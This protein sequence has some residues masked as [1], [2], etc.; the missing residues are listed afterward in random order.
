M[1]NIDMAELY[2]CK[3]NIFIKDILLIALNRYGVIAD[4][5]DKRIRFKIKLDNTE[6]VF[7]M[8]VCV[9]TYPSPFLLKEGG[10]IFLNNQH[11]GILIEIEHD[12]CD[13]TYF[14]RNKTELTL[15]SNMRSQC[16][17]CKFCGSYQLDPED[18]HDLNT[19]DKLL[20]YL[21]ALLKVNG[22]NSFE[23]LDRITIC[24]GCFE[25]EEN[26][27]KHLIMVKNVFKKYGFNKRIR[28]IGSQLRSE[29]AFDI[30]RDE[31]GL[32]SLTLTLECFSR[33]NELMRLEKASLNF[34]E[35]KSVLERALYHNFSVN[36]LYILGLDKL[37]IMVK[38]MEELKP[39]INRFPGIQ[40]F[41]NFTSEQENYR[42]TEAKE[43]PYYLEARK[44]VEKI[45]E[46]EQY[47]PRSWE[48][49]RGLFYFTYN[50][51]D[52]KGI[53]I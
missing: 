26:L 49:Y 41:Q 39:Y 52:F 50:G 38:G 16:K 42:L 51:E 18:V 40:I 53:K 14:R 15:N 34:A 29:K 37:E 31:I 21:E 9:N 22:M 6:T 43:I 19:E 25:N 24:T 27:V 30:L 36:Y 48:N 32:F 33:R 12:T 4:I 7:Y 45:Y 1:F 2:A 44:K 23:K 8:A 17:G 5:E 20:R 47:K 11:I 28:Y 3:Y 13:A 10:D 35:V 46:N